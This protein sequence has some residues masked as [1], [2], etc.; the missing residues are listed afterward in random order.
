MLTPHHLRYTGA[1]QSAFRLHISDIEIDIAAI[2][3]SSPDVAEQSILSAQ[4]RHCGTYMHE[5]E[6]HVWWGRVDPLLIGS[7][8]TWTPGCLINPL[9][10]ANRSLSINCLET[11]R[12][13]VFEAVL[14]VAVM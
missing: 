8:F 14:I 10:W 3:L 12:V 6:N 9:H 7:V 5:V 11:R 2:S 13:W 1:A 4:K